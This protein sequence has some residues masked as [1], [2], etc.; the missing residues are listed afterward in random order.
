M[1]ELIWYASATTSQQGKAKLKCHFV[2][3]RKHWRVCVCVCGECLN[4]MGVQSVH[5]CVGCVCVHMEPGEGMEGL[6]LP[7]V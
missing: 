5:T 6:F 7:A 4:M 1:K 3:I 2:F